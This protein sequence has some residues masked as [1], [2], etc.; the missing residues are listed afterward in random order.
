SVTCPCIRAFSACSTLICISCC[1][2]RS[3]SVGG[4]QSHPLAPAKS[5]TSTTLRTAWRAVLVIRSSSRLVLLFRFFRCYSARRGSA[6]LK[7][8]Q[9]VLHRLVGKAEHLGGLGDD[10]IA[11]SH[12]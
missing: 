4:H 8:F 9:S 11:S 7:F 3:C 2:I 12:C 6:Q 1:P 10:A 5:P